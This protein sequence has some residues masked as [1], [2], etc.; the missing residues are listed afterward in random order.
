[1]NYPLCSSFRSLVDTLLDAATPLV[2]CRLLPA[3]RYVVYDRRGDALGA[4]SGIERN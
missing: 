3:F 2:W 4:F 1:M